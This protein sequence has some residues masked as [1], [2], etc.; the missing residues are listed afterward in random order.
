MQF[1]PLFGRQKRYNALV[2][3]EL[4]PIED[5]EKRSFPS[6][7]STS[8]TAFAKVFLVLFGFSVGIC[9]G[10]WLQVSNQSKNEHFGVKQRSPIP[11]DVFT[12]RQNIP[13]IPDER[14]IGP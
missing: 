1:L 4:L 2:S 11:Q 3:Q 9:L 7:G 8:T 13:F 6:N 14:Y 5:F 12:R 10:F